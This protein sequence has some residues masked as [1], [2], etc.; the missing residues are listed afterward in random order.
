[1]IYANACYAPG[2]S[3]PGTT[4]ATATQALQRVSYYSRQAL[5]ALGAS[6]YFATDHG[7]ASL[8]HDLLT[9]AGTTYGAIYAAHVQVIGKVIGVFRAL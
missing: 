6:G 7:A 8:V 4:A 5:S 9:K 3:E 1:M 2:A